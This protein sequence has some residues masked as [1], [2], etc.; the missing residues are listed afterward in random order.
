MSGD[1]RLLASDIAARDDALDVSR[2]FIVQAPAGSG[3]TELLIQRYLRLLAIVDE[4]EEIIAITF[5]RKAAAEMQHRIVTALRAAS[6]GERP[7]EA[8]EQRTAALATAALAR[9]ADRQWGLLRSPSRM[10]IQ[11]LDSLNAA[12]A[13]SRPISSPA[14]AGGVRVVVDAELKALH[15]AAAVSTLDYLTEPGPFCDA[16]TEVLG[17]L[18]N[19]TSIYVDYLSRMLGTRDQWLPFTGSGSLTPEEAA[20]LRAALEANLDAAVSERLVLVQRLFPASVRH[21]LAALFDRA[22]CNLRD[23]ENPDSPICALAG[24]TDLP[25]AEPQSAPQWAAVAELLLTKGGTFR[26]QVDKRLGFPADEKEPKDTMKALLEE[27]AAHE[28]L[29]EALHDARASSRRLQRRAMGRTSGIVPP[30]A[31]GQ[32][33]VTAPLQ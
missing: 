3:K 31:A 2:S 29:R 33:R 8:H 18:D 20:A 12:I 1:E 10:R 14:S 19:N 28:Q 11:T 25:P 30:V 23:G 24:L 26:K 17:H 21:E 4:P 32:H 7:E 9:D 5:T 16:A 15:R 22:A 27:L 13:R 6:R